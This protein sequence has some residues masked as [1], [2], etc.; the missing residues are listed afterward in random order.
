MKEGV[1]PQSP[2][3]ISFKKIYMSMYLDETNNMISM[4]GFRSLGAINFSA[5]SIRVVICNTFFSKDP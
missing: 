4:N 1:S 5:K 3:G 2:I